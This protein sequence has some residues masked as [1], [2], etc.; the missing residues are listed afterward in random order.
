MPVPGVYVL[1]VLSRGF[2][3]PTYLVQLAEASEED[4]EPL[5]TPFVW[6]NKPNL[7][8][9][10]EFS[11]PY[12]LVVEGT[13]IDYDKTVRSFDLWQTL[14]SNPL[15]PLMAIGTLMALGVPRLLVRPM[16]AEGRR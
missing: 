15:I 4:I 13:K 3:Y 16:M 8:H 14:K 10:P 1:S 11:I 5:V 12:P 9:V 6:G 2:V 7:T